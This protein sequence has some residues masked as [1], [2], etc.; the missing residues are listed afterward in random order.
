METILDLS[1]SY[2]VQSITFLKFHF[3]RLF[4][5][6]QM[7]WSD[8]GYLPKIEKANMDGTARVTLV[9]SG[10]S[11]VNSLALDLKNKLL[12]WCDAR[13]DK[14][15]RVNFM[16]NNR[17]VVLSLSWSKR[18]HPFGLALYGDVLF[19]SDWATKS[20]HRFN[21]TSS[22]SKEVVQGLGRPMEIHIHDFKNIAAI[23]MIFCFRVKLETLMIKGLLNLIENYQKKVNWPILPM[24]FL[25]LIKQLIRINRTSGKATGGMHTSLIPTIVPELWMRLVFGGSINIIL[26]L[27]AVL[28]K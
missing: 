19:W 16:G 2:K 3:T 26:V 27:V 6:R 28:I 1:L 24:G 18:Y 17:A 9:S 22:I 15:E 14:I 12:Y 4:N 5:H 23:G 20:V 11:W 21:L 10:L 13:L 25:E 7:F 8:W